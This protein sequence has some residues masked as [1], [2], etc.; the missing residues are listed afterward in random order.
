MKKALYEVAIFIVIIMITLIFFTKDY[1]KMSV[2]TI[3]NLAISEIST[4]TE[5][6]KCIFQIH[7]AD[8]KKDK[9]S[10]L[11]IIKNFLRD[12]IY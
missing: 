10:L 1:N 7:S 9:I 5:L 4:C 6:K 11:K 8:K 12:K 3:S 2:L